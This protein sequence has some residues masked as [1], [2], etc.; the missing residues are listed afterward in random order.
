M[1][2]Y[3]MTDLE[4]AA[5]VVSAQEWTSPGQRYY[6]LAKKFLTLEVN[7]AI[8]GFCEG[9]ATEI[10]VADG[11]GAGGLNVDLLDPRAEYLRGWPDDAYP[12]CLDSSFDFS[13]SI[14]QHAKAGTRGGHLAHTQGFHVLDI[15]INGMSV[16]EFG[17]LVMCASEL[18]V[19]TIFGAGDGAFTQEAKTL[20][21]G[22]ETVAVKWGVKSQTGDDMNTE[23][24]RA[25]N[26]AAR[27]LQPERARAL[28]RAG[29][30]KAI[31]RAQKEDFG[32]V[33]LTP[34]FEMVTKCR[35]DGDRDY[36]TIS[37]KTHPTSVIGVLNVRGETE[38]LEE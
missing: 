29:S 8:D 7:A 30:L 25:Y 26:F 6:E 21:P 10:L 14:G 3:I 23:Q 24:Y 17:E 13:A 22:I 20:V 38:K 36:K 9:G 18:G 37:R 34:P 19:R 5:G 11:H 32:I 4:S 33:P 16:G 27:H 12:F 35:P 1:K 15:S 2:I 31:Q 28:I